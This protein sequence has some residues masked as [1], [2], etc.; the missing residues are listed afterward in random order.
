MQDTSQV[1]D[2]GNSELTVLN[3]GADAHLLEYGRLTTGAGA[4]PL[5]GLGTYHAYLDGSNIK[6]DF[7][8]EAVGIATT[9]ALN[10]I[11]FANSDS[12]TTGIGTIELDRARLEGRTTSI[13]ASGSPGITTVMQNTDKYDAHISL[14]K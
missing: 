3:D 8:S 12:T 11:F 2:Y 6:V 1:G 14:H 4:F 7:I 13:S 9:G 10:T 5:T